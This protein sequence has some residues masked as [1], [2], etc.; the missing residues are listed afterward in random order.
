VGWGAPRAHDGGTELTAL[1]E[2]ATAL[3]GSVDLATALSTSSPCG[4]FRPVPNGYPLIPGQGRHA[5]KYLCLIYTAER[6]LTGL[7]SGQFAAIERECVA[8]EDSLR[9]SGQLLAVEAL[10][11]VQAATTVRVRGNDVSITDGPFAETK[12][13]L[14]GFYLIEARD[15]N[16][17]IG[18]A[19]KIPPAHLGSIEIRPVRTLTAE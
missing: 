16:E 17:A 19:A 5:L 10:E 6:A 15:L 18:V 4:R 14:A 12:E 9:A 7:S 1:N 13:Q 11:P 3:N 8:Y 2:I